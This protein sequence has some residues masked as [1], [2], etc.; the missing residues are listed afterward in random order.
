MGM[1][2]RSCRGSAGVR[3]ATSRVLRP[4]RFL[5]TTG[6]A[7]V[8]VAVGLGYCGSASAQ[9]LYWRGLTDS[10]WNGNDDNWSTDKAGTTPA[11]ALPGA[12]TDVV[13]AWDDASGVVATTLEQNFSINSLRFEAGTTTPSEVTIAPGANSATRLTTGTGGVTL[14]AGGPAAT[15]SAPVVLGAAQ[16]WS[17]NLTSGTF[18]IAGPLSLTTGTADPAR[19]FRL[20]GSGPTLIS[21]TVTNGAGGNSTFRKQGPGTLTVTGSVQNNA[22]LALDNGLIV[23]DGGALSAGTD[24]ALATGGGNTMGVGSINGSSALLYVRGGTLAAQR[25][26]IGVSGSGSSHVASLVLDG[27]SIKSGTWASGGAGVG[28]VVGTTAASPDM[29]SGLMIKSGTVNIHDLDLRSISTSGTQASVFRMEGGGL[30]NRWAL[31]T[32]GQNSEITITGGTI[33]RVGAGANIA[34]GFQ[35]TGTSVLNVVGGLI[36]NTGRDVTVRQFNEAGTTPVATINLNGGRL[37]T[38]RMLVTL[39]GGT[40]WVNFNGGTLEPGSN[41]ATLVASSMTAAYVNGAFGSFDG[42]AV[43]DTNGRNTTIAAPLLAPAGNGLSGLALTAAGS[44]YIGA[45][46]VRIDGGGG[47]GATG[48]ATVDLDPASPTF[49]QLTG[50]VLTNPG[51]NYTSTPTIAL[52]GGGGSGAS[53][54]AGALAANASGGLRK[55]GAGTLTLSAANTYTAATTIAG[56]TLALAAGASIATSEAIYLAATTAGLDVSAQAGISIGSGNGIGGI[57][58]VTGNLTLDTGADFIVDPAALDL[59]QALT[60]NGT[61]T[62]PDGFGIASLVGLSGPLDW[63]LVAQGNYALLTNAGPFSNIFNWGEENAADIGGG[64]TAYFFEQPGTLGLAVVPEPGTVFLG[65]AGCFGVGWY[66][67]RRRGR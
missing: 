48:Y 23:V 56:G 13:F 27:G 28:I 47:S 8:A 5:A 51:V 53:V 60:V 10:A 62:L 50:V 19:T 14:T 55:L 54:S 30:K 41:D 67:R 26:N 17:N 36:D 1:R 64:R 33:D 12:T 3:K 22:L 18:R 52:L 61:M 7:I 31:Y 42:G 66:L 38:N 25:F 63:S 45:P 2:S 29:Y 20:T 46:Y 40:G 57:G 15:I 35:Q 6:M 32:R 65:L 4:I 44:G 49:G 11:T 34:L 9:T 59:G 39:A 16:D 37:I 43:I 24:A 58:T 21:G